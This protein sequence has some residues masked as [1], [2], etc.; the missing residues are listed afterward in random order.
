MKQYLFQS[1]ILIVKKVYGFKET[2]TGLVVC[3]VIGMGGQLRLILGQLV[4]PIGRAVLDFGNCWNDY[5]NYY[6]GGL[7]K[8]FLNGTVIA[9]APK[10]TPSVTVVFDFEIGSVLKIAEYHGHIIQFNSLDI[11]QCNEESGNFDIK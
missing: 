10:N 2:G 5:S 11:I 4:L 8:A 7:V 9:S 6:V 1:G 3:A